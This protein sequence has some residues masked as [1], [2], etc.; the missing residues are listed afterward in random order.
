MTH[1]LYQLSIVV[2]L[3]LSANGASN[4]PKLVNTNSNYLISILTRLTNPRYSSSPILS[5]MEDG[6]VKQ[7]NLNPVE[8]TAL[9]NVVKQLP[10]ANIKDK[11]ITQFQ[12]QL[13]PKTLS[14]ISQYLNII[15][16]DSKV[17][18][19]LLGNVYSD[20]QS[21]QQCLSDKLPGNVS[22][23]G[24]TYC[25]LLLAS[26]SY[27][28]TTPL[29]FTNSNHVLA[30]S[31]GSSWTTTITRNL[32][33]LNSL[34]TVNPNVT[35]I[36]IQDI[37]FD[38]NRFQYN[39]DQLDYIG[40]PLYAG[41]AYGN[42]DIDF[43]TVSYAFISNVSILN[44]PGTGVAIYSG[45]VKD[46]TIFGA[47]TTGIT[48][49]SNQILGDDD[50]QNDGYVLV[51]NNIF[52]L[53]GTAGLT[54]NGWGI[55][56]GNQ[57]IQNR[58]EESDGV[59]GGQLT[60]WNTASK[61]DLDG[62]Y[63]NANGEITPLSGL[64]PTYNGLTGNLSGNSC[65]VVGN[66]GAT[67]IE[68]DGHSTSLRGNSIINHLAGTKGD[69]GAGILIHQGV[70]MYISS[71][72]PNT[73]ILAAINNNPY[74]IHVINNIN[75]PTNIA[76][77]PLYIINS[78]QTGILID[79]GVTGP[80]FLPNSYGSSCLLHNATNS[81]FNWATCDPIKNINYCYNST[82]NNSDKTTCQ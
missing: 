7:F 82:W 21:I 25:V 44:S 18:P 63:L 9:I 69:G 12:T 73:G 77:G 40:C 53:N 76:I 34:V 48:T 19:V 28:I 58:F 32:E 42:I 33:T 55:V 52:I 57:F 66:L 67:G 50:S 20:L 30:G 59:S 43:R 13:Q 60:V 24:L 47:R 71:L 68:I 56:R 74:G 64:T 17:S 45:L 5:L 39:F 2:L 46:S 72:D 65:P 11:V 3:L 6:Y 81:L 1:K 54:M 27:Q 62:N 41:A 26:N 22:A 31:G 23:N 78:Q 29:I 36:G 37:T 38:G 14:S 51:S 70:G 8:T 35:N 75:P 15:T 80:G 79:T 10:V 4:K 49:G 16:L 61:I